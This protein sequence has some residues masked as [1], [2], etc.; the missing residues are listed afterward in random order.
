MPHRHRALRG[1][2]PS[3][4]GLSVRNDLFI[5]SLFSQVM[6]ELLKGDGAKGD[7]SWMR[8]KEILPPPSPCQYFPPGKE[9]KRDEI[10]QAAL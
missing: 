8:W 2:A 6:G 5:C 7:G 10:R 3:A 4:L 9:Q 1:D